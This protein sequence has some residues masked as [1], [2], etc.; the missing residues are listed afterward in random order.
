MHT[1]TVLICDDNDAVHESLKRFLEKENIRVLSVFRGEDV[2]TTMDA[3]S[4][5]LIVLD[6]MLPGTSGTDICYQIRKTSNVP[7]IFLSAKGEEVDR[8]IGLEL[9]ADDYVTKPFSPREVTIRV[10]RILSR[11]SPESPKSL[12][13]YQELRLN[14]DTF[15]VFV[16]DNKIEMSAKEVKL[17]AYL[18]ANPKKVLTRESILKNIWE[19]DCYC[20]TRAVDAVV[21]RIRQKLPTENVTFSIQTVYGAG[22]RLGDITG[23]N[24]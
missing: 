3:N 20:D 15:E 1:Y 12:L 16:N 8:I 23:S 14:P 5:D 19:Y 10:K 4:I 17:L 22:Y 24:T 13:C 7:I 18:M 9:G 2:L 11:I 6:I 21:K